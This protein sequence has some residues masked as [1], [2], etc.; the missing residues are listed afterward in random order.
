MIEL[1][2][3]YEV[4][5]SPKVLYDLLS[6]REHNISHKRLPPWKDHI[7]FIDSKPYRK[8]FLVCVGETVVGSCYLSKQ[9]EVGIFIFKQY[10]G[11]GYGLETVNK[12]VTEFNPLKEIPGIR[13]GQFIAN[14][15][16]ENESSARLFQKL[17]F[18]HI[19]NIYRL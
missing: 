18:S 9:N 15:N 11:K 12:L 4:Q 13:S 10:Q 17:G 6:E 16:P 5:E 2:S 8:W 14:I 19:G 3:I 1:V 7:K